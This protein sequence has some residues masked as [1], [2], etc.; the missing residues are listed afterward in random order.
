M[1]WRNCACADLSFISYCI[2]ID[3]KVLT[4]LPYWF[5]PQLFT[6]LGILL[7]LLLL[8]RLLYYDSHDDYCYIIIKPA[9]QAKVS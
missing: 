1:A 9:K 8:L 2:I 5:Q 3:L 6:L 7:L 4:R